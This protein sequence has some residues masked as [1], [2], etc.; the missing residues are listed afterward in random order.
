MW[1]RMTT[2]QLPVLVQTAITAAMSCLPYRGMILPKKR[3]SFAGLASTYRSLV[4][5]RA[6]CLISTEILG[7]VIGTLYCV[8]FTEINFSQTDN[9]TKIFQH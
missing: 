4:Y 8:N 7:F 1:L 6:V 3:Q 5:F 2:S 9:E